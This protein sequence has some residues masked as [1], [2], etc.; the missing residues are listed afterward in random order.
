MPLDPAPAELDSVL[1]ATLPVEG[2]PRLLS[3]GEM[4]SVM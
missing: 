3:D 2:G 4:V 1:R